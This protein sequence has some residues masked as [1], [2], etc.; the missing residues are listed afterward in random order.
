VRTA[1]T[2]QQWQAWWEAERLWIQDELPDLC[3]ELAGDDPAAHSRA[4]R[5]LLE[6]PSSMHKTAL[7]LAEAV[8]RQDE[9]LAL[10]SLQCLAGLGCP[11]ALERLADARSDSRQAIRAAAEA[12][13]SARLAGSR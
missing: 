10:R 13:L 5:L 9:T 1:E 6:H 12:A 7:A 11:T 4:L 2:E 8:R 3:R